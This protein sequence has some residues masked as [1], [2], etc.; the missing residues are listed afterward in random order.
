MLRPATKIYTDSSPISGIGVFAMDEIKPGELIEEAPILEIS[1]EQIE[2]LAKTELLNFF[3][4]EGNGFETPAIIL[5]F[6]SLYNHSYDPNARFV[7]KMGEKILRFV[8]LKR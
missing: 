7:K 3:F 5:G 6:G 8:A 4:G 2:D 1:E